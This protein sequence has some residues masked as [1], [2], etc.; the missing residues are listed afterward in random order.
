MLVEKLRK[1]MKENILI[2]LYRYYTNDIT[3]ERAAENANVPIYLLVQFVNDNDLPI[4]HTDKDV[5]DGLHKVLALMKKEHMDTRKLE[6]L[7][8]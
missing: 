7:P 8:A 1:E 3:F 5:T 2:A 4:V 6:L